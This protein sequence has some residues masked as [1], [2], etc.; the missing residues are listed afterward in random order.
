MPVGIN[1]RHFAAVPAIRFVPGHVDDGGD[2]EPR[3]PW[4]DLCP[5]DSGKIEDL[6]LYFSVIRQEKP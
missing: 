4:P 6:V 2:G 1:N 3:W 5:T